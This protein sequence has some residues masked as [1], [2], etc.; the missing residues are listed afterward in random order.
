MA[1]AQ[2]VSYAEPAICE[3]GCCEEVSQTD[4]A[5]VITGECLHVCVSMCVC[6]HECHMYVCDGCICVCAQVCVCVC[7]TCDV[8]VM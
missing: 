5:P 7:V 2:D 3:V 4:T 8:C 6:V 1:S